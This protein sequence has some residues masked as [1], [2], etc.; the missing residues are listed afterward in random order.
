MDL[1]D[2]ADLLSLGGDWGPQNCAGVDLDQEIQGSEQG[3]WED[4]GFLKQ[5]QRRRNVTL[6]FH[7]D[8]DWKAREVDEKMDPLGRCLPSHLVVRYLL[9]EGSRG[10]VHLDRDQTLVPGILCPGLPCHP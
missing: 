10:V 9:Q 5:F 1:E 3:Y 6:V 7:R 2:P 8:G 4:I